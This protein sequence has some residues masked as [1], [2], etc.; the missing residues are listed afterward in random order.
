MLTIECPLT[1]HLQKGQAVTTDS[2]RQMRAGIN[3][4]Y[5][6][7]LHRYVVQLQSDFFWPST[8]WGIQEVEVAP[9]FFPPPLAE[10]RW[11]FSH[12]NSSS[13]GMYIVSPSA[14][15]KLWWL[16]P[17]RDLFNRDLYHLWVSLEIELAHQN[18][19]ST[20]SDAKQFLLTTIYSSN[21]Y[22]GKNTIDIH[23][24]FAYKEII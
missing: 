19:S 10:F 1:L 12:G 8:M 7:P 20:I 14:L 18:H 16:V 4:S 17:T 24:H 2:W 15:P 13:A 21:L 3:G 11:N 9:I 6:G 22:T 23:G 5:P